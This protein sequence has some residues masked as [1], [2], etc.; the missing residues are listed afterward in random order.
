MK[1]KLFVLL[2]AA[3]TVAGTITAQVLSG[4]FKYR[5][6]QHKEYPSTEALITDADACIK[7][8]AASAIQYDG[9]AVDVALLKTHLPIIVIN[10]DEAIPGVPY[11][12]EGNYH[13][14]YTTTSA[15]DTQLLAAMRIIDNRNTYNSMADTPAL[16]TNIHIRVRGNTSRW[17]DKKSYAIDTVDG[18][19]NAADKK[20]LG[21]E[22]AH[23]WA[24]H[25]PFLDKT[26]MRNYMAMSISGELMD[27]A[28]DVRFCEVVLN[29]EY[30]GLYVLMETVSRG[31]GRI[32]VE[33]PNKMKN[34][35]GYIVEIDNA[36]SLPLTALDNF[37][38]YTS[39]LRKDSFFDLVYPGKSQLTPELK[40]YVE[41][42]M[43]A[44]E[45]ALYSYDHDT[46]AY[47]FQKY[48]DIDEFVDYFIL[49]E[50]FLQHD[51]GNLSTYFYKDINGVYKPCVWDFNN[52]LENISVISD[53]DFYIRKFVS[54]QAPWFWMMIKDDSYINRIISRYRELRKGILSDAWLTGYI[55]DTKNYLG[56]AVDR[57]FAVWGYSFNPDN[58][59]MRNKLRPDE[60]NPR[61][62][63]AAVAQMTDTL[64]ERLAWLDENIEILRQYCHESAVKKFNH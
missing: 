46:L 20:L 62:Y 18:S 58:L 16:E 4:N 8:T 33:K 15:G 43:S 7:P 63:D 50:V 51:T 38:K 6:H 11:Y 29:G 54:V 45:K 37:T 34:V 56:S 44:F 48:V 27:Y 55:E 17:F 41:K 1:K 35:T 10:T 24:L 49:M 52:D 53:D 22:K 31:K 47:G 30:Q 25:G 3:V 14:M 23:E 13:R 64:L 36:T 60:R 19:G 9:D 57:N 26:L 2:I 28:P 40:A 61:S 12:G 42:D 5:I 32:D 21:M 59:D 39:I